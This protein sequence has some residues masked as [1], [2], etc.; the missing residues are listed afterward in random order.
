MLTFSDFAHGEAHCRAQFFE[1]FANFVHGNASLLCRVPAQFESRLDLFA[2][3]SLQSVRQR[4]A[5]FQTEAHIVCLFVG[6]SH[7]AITFFARHL[8]PEPRRRLEL[9]ARCTVGEFYFR[10]HQTGMSAAININLDQ[11][12]FPGNFVAQLA[13]PPANGRGPKRGELFWA[14]LD[15]ALLPVCTAAHLESQRRG[16][17]FF[18]ETNLPACGLCCQITLCDDIAPRT[19]KFF[20]QQFK[21]KLAL[22]FP[23]VWKSLLHWCEVRMLTT[24]NLSVETFALAKKRL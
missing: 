6:Q 14:E 3:N 21:Q 10:D 4:L 12:V 13:Q 19:L 5:Q 23:A 22:D 7:V 8:P 1:V 24:I 9:P 18:A 16:F 2:K 11:Q 20:R 17:P 15:L